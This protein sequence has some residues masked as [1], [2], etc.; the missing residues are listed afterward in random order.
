LILNRH[1][2][3]SRVLPWETH[4][5]VVVEW[6]AARLTTGPDLDDVVMFLF[7]KLP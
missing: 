6:G 5:H 3:G 7:D 1:I 4:A 2:S